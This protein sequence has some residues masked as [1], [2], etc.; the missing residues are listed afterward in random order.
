MDKEIIAKVCHEVNKA[1]CEAIGDHSQKSWDEADEWQK[2]SSIKGV[3]FAL[4][5]NATPET[6]H[7]A[8]LKE[9][10]NA[11]WIYGQVKDAEKKTDPSIVAYEALPENQKIKDHLFVAVVNSL[12]DL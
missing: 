12:K 3:E 6:Q 8:W 10:M 4:T 7:E 2:Q 9:K 1:F 5:G 11:G